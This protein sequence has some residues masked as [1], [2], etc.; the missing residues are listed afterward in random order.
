MTPLRIGN[1]SG[2]YGDRFAAWR[3]MLDGGELDVLTG[4]YLAEL[5]MLILGRDRLT[6]PGARLREDVPA[7][8]GGRASAPPLDRGV[9]IVTNAGGLNPAG[10]GRR[11]RA[12]AARLGVPCRVGYVEGDALRAP[13][14]A[15]PPTPTSARSASPRAC[16]AGADVVVTGRVTD[17]SLVVGPAA[18]HFG[19]GRDDL[20][21]LAGATVAGHVL[22]CGAQATGGNFSFF[23]ELPDGGR[24]P[25]FPIAEVHADGSAVI[26]K[27]PGTGGAVTVETVT[28]QLL[29]EIGAPAYLGPDVVTR[30]DTVTL[31]PDGPD[32]VRVTGVRGSPP[33]PTLKVGVNH[34]RRLPQR[35][36]VRADRARHRG[37]G[38]AG[39]GAARR[40][41]RQGRAGVHAGPHRPPGRRRHRGGERAAAR[42]PEG[43]RPEA[44]RAGVLGRPRWSWRWPRT[45]AAR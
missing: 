7:P 43:R 39:P 29:Y 15:R 11:H 42:T 4:D 30:L 22:E 31:A 12:L 33:P 2:F 16:D 25:G 45:R 5:T 23:T 1:A 6:R 18:A 34:A 8:D 19:W 35:D 28:A 40:R 44:G 3:E 9:K 41:G 27:H 24:R 17:A 10:P 21:A 32:R 37:Q 20:D 36:D 38:G 26:T 13:G 14:R